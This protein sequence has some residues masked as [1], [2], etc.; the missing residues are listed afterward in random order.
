[1]EDAGVKILLAA[2]VLVLAAGTAGWFIAQPSEHAVS[3]GLPPQSAP[4]AGA[5]P[6][7]Q[8]PSGRS[9]EV[10]FARDGRLVEALR[11]HRATRRVAT[12]ALDALLAGPTR[13]ERA[14]GLSSE[15]PAGTRLLGVSIA[16]GI[17]RV[18]LTSDFESAAATR[19]LQLR[20]AQVV[21]TAT[22]FPTVKKV[23]FLVNGTPVAALGS[24]VGRDAYP[25][26]APAVSSIAGTW[27][28][29]PR[30]AFG[31]L[32][33]R[34][35]AWT[36]SEWL[37]LGRSGPR[38]VFAS[39]NPARNA[40]RKLPS[41]RGLGRS[42]RV[43][44]TG[45]ELVAWGSTVAA[46]DPAEGRWRSLPSPPVAGPPK[47]MAWTGRELAG[48]TSSGGA[49]YRPQRAW[50]ALPEAPLSG[51][52]VWTG[53]ELVVVSPAAAA[54]FSPGHGWRRLPPPPLPRP[55]A[56]AIWDGDEL[57][58]VGGRS[59]PPVGLAYSP[60]TNAWR[61]LAPSSGRKDAAAVWT[62]SR[63]LLWGGETGTPGGLVIPPHGLAYEPK[64]DS[65]SPLPQ[66][67]LK[68]RLNP[69]AAW[70]GHSLLLWGGDPGFAD[71]A[72]FTPA[73]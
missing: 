49:A 42:F 28:S 57:L 40:W 44:W 60:S 34:A 4:I 73:R 9:F 5:Q 55:G 69:L 59:A 6:T 45:H 26:L 29:L 30:S 22:Q 32:T 70:T 62:G 23:R 20:L 11:T 27:R 2:V 3:L 14:S 41:P 7:G 48:W 53:K 50:R 18:D 19:A 46:F 15:I 71:G 64:A 47:L 72:A 38:T 24:A 25:A 12:A 8:L 51:A 65:W 63:L 10:W 37:L 35:S 43:A 52:S 66:A 36:G 33:S 56:S 39:Y 54:A 31:A 13:S 67:P 68:G 16:D 58:V 21:Y 61:E 17:A 1:M